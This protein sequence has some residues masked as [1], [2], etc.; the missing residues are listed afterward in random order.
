[1]STNTFSQL[2]SREQPIG[3]HNHLLGMDP[4]RLDRVEPGTF[5]GQKER[6]NAHTFARL[7]NLLVV[8]SSIQVRTILLT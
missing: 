5:G 2:L 6:Q 7:L 8:L 4:L 3:F 1:M